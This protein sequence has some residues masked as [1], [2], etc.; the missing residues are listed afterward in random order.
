VNFNILRFDTLDSTNTEAAKQAR[1]GADEGLCV[2]AR[3]QTAGRG[4][5][6]RTWVSQA[7]AGLYFS[8]VLRPIFAPDQL[9]L[10]TLMAA[11]ALYDALKSVGL[12]PDIKWVND[13]L[14]GDRKIG[15]ILAE[16][17]ESPAGLAVVVGIGVNLTK[18]AISEHIANTATSLEAELGRPIPAIEIETSLSGFIKYWYDVLN[19][20]N[21]GAEILRAWQSRS[22]YSTGKHVRVTVSEAEF[23]GVTDG[24]EA[25]GALRVRTSEGDLRIVQ[26][27][28]VER[29]R[30]V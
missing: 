3:R 15:G 11:I 30:G 27:G 7:D 21:G 13:L 6:G 2:I 16:A 14:I 5:H 10:I 23:E 24:L 28:D 8:L 20:E 22:S 25:N 29:L 9:P 26:A 17:Q 4:R 19:G 1:L 12:R 18:G